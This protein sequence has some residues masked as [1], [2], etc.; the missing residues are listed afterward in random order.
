MSSKF[1]WIPG[2]LQGALGDSR[3]L[4][5]LSRE[6]QK[7]LKTLYVTVGFQVLFR[8][9]QRVLRRV[10]MHSKTFQRSSKEGVQGLATEFKKSFC[11]SFRDSEGFQAASEAISR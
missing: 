8:N 10:S 1:W 11:G 5:P 4:Q 6:L 9:P 2:G 3:G 7:G